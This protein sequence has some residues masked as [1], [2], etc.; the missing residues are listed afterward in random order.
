MNF[1]DLNNELEPKTTTHTNTTRVQVACRFRPINAHEKEID[2]ST[3]TTT[4]TSQQPS[5]SSCCCDFG[6]GN[7]SVQINDP[8]RN[9]SFHFSFDRILPPGTTQNACYRQVAAPLVDDVLSGIN[10]CITAYGQTGSGKTH[11][12]FGPGFDMQDTTKKGGVWTCD[13]A[14]YGIIPRLFEDLFAKSRLQ[15]DTFQCDVE[16]AFI[17]IYNEKVSD[18]ITTLRLKVRQNVHAGAFEANALFSSV[19]STEDVLALVRE[20]LQNRVTAKTNANVESSRSHAIL[21][22][23]ILRKDLQ[24]SE[25]ISSTLHLVDLAGS[26]K[27]SKTGAFGTRLNEASSINKS[28]HALSKVIGA[29]SV[30]D[31]RGGSGSNKREKFIPYRDSVLTKLLKNT[32]GGNSKTV[33]LLCGSVHHY[34][35]SETLSTLEFGSRAQS[36]TNRPVQNVELTAEHLRSAIATSMDVLSN[37]HRVLKNVSRQVLLHR[38]LVQQILSRIPSDAA[39]LQNIFRS[40]PLLRSLPQ[41]HKWGDV[42]LPVHILR[43]VFGYSGLVGML[44]GME[45]SKEWYTLLT[46]TQGWDRGVWK[47][48]FDQEKAVVDVV[49]EEGKK[50]TVELETGDTSWWWRKKATHWFS[51]QE[52]SRKQKL[53][54]RFREEEGKRVGRS[55]DL[56]LLN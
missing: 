17:Q 19:D 26:E 18:L 40:L 27:V 48:A 15:A 46:S 33:V 49:L 30:T 41:V 20:G 43:I 13:R 36:I 45:V 7:T 39:V 16:V 24:T 52:K 22:T 8:S 29:L 12:M 34:N 23:R 53:R 55:E 1:A 10:A 11:T 14:D 9:H 4:S 28:L 35:I 21:T 56:V 31:K 47:V 25:L 44:K 50:A 2:S 51:D 6:H 3:T 54:R 38:T 32:L 42:Y 37:Q 5:S